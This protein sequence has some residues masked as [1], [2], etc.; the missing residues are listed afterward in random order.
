M[1]PEL[2]DIPN[3]TVVVAEFPLAKAPAEI[4]RGIPFG[5]SRDDGTIAGIVP[6]IRWTDY[7]TPG[8]GAWRC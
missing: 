3:L 8:K 6:A 1:K 2:N 5:F 7:A 4:R